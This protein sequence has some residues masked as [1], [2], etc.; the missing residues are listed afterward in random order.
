MTTILTT[1]EKKLTKSYVDKDDFI[2][3]F[4][5]F[6]FLPNHDREAVVLHNAHAYYMQY[7]VGAYKRLCQ[8]WKA[9]VDDN[10]LQRGN[11][12]EFQ[13]CEVSG[14]I[15]FFVNKKAPEIVIIE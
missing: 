10:G 15:C 14:R 5:T 3:P 1:F 4:H 11:V 2:F 13:A 12:L 8:G 7:K 6:E 9:F